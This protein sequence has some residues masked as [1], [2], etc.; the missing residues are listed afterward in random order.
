TDCLSADTA[1]TASY[2]L[3]LHDAHPICFCRQLRKNLARLLR[4]QLGLVD[5]AA[6]AHAPDAI[7]VEAHW[8]YLEIDLPAS[9]AAM[10]PR[11]EEVD[12]K[13]TRLN[14]SHVKISY[15]VFCLKKK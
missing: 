6:D 5:K 9:H 2:T 14:S 12:R 1:V 11:I 10:L 7:V 8:D 13:S 4:T 3:P 15:A